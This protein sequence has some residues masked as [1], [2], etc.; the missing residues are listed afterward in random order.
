MFV[1][2]NCI[3]WWNVWYGLVINCVDFSI[4]LGVIVEWN[5]VV[6]VLWWVKWIDGLILKMFLSF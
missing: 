3:L 2:V 1:C 4:L 5:Y 6:F